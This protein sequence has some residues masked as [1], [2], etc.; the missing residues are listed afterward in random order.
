MF[1]VT[2]NVIWRHC[3]ESRP[4]VPSPI[5]HGW[6]TASDGSLQ[7]VWMTK[8]PSPDDVLQSLFHSCNKTTCRERCSCTGRCKCF[9]NEIDCLNEFTMDPEIENNLYDEDSNSDIDI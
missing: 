4:K 5:G 9:Q 3:L 2:S 6:T 1:R 8:P 7:Y